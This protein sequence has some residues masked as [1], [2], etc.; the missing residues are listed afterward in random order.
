MTWIEGTSALLPE[1][2]FDV[3]VLTSHVAQFFVDDAEWARTLADLARALVPGGRL[4]FDAR[5]PADR[6]WERWNPVDS[7]RVVTLPD[8]GEVRAWT[9]VTRVRDG[10]VDFTHHGEFVV[11]AG[12]GALA[13][14]S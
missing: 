13:P 7:H 12:V 11:V 10:V 9:K 4:V 5:D 14:V 8:G 6:R 2:A 1:R 3:A